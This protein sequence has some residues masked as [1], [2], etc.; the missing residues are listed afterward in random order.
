[1][2]E[3]GYGYRM[4]NGGWSFPRYVLI[5]LYACGPVR[6]VLH[7]PSAPRFLSKILDFGG[8]Y[9]RRKVRTGG[10][11]EMNRIVN[12]YGAIPLGLGLVMLFCWIVRTSTVG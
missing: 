2:V 10:R 11:E 5:V 3:M 4:G 12:A 9:C 6:A 7:T 8:S 1:M